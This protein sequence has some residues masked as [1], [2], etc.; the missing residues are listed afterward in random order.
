MIF[1]VNTLDD[2]SDADLNNGTPSDANGNVSLRAAV[3]QS[4]FR[5]KGDVW[6]EFD[7]GLADQFGKISLELTDTVNITVPVDINGDFGGSGFVRITGDDVFVLFH[8]QAA[9]GAF[10]N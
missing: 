5:G 3:E 2:T 10:N 7:I 1:T 8:H 4:N 9:G 6:I